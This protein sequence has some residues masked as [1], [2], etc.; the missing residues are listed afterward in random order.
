M[1][2]NDA[3]DMLYEY[4]DLPMHDTRKRAIDRHIAGCPSCREQF[5]VWR[6]SAE[7]I[8]STRVDPGPS[9]SG[10]SVSS[11]VMERIYRNESWRMPVVWKTYALSYRLRRNIMLMFAMCLAIFAGAFIHSLLDEPKAADEFVELTGIIDTAHAKGGTAIGYTMFEGIP[12]ASLSAPTV[13][14]MGPIQ[15]YTDYLMALSILGFVCV[16]LFMNWLSR[17]RS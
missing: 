6:Q 16:L 13:I 2:C 8:R 5:D 11:R 12:V 1:N 15:T 14:R 17:L 4:W 10:K 7:L 9:A 3:M